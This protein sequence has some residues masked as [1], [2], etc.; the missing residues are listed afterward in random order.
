APSLVDACE[1]TFLDRVPID[2]KRALAQHAG[3]R[4]ALEG[5]GAHVLTLDSSRAL[6][7]SVFIEDTALILDELAIITR[8][9][10]SS[11]RSEP[12]FVEPALTIYR[13]LERIQAPGTLDGG[14]A[15]RIGHTLFVGVSTR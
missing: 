6:P 8:P 1:L 13:R 5:A 2:F 3:Y 14:D 7:D 12:G 4:K 9:G 15:L 11:R 10:A